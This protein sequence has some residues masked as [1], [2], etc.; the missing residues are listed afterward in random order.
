MSIPA[1]SASLLLGLLV[2]ATAL[3][4]MTPSAI[5]DQFFKRIVAGEPG[6]AFDTLMGHSRLDEVEPAE[7]SA[8]KGRLGE[9]ML[10]YGTPGS[11]EEIARKPYGDSIVRLVYITK[12]TDSPLVWNL[13][14]YR[15]SSDWQLLDFDFS[16]NLERLE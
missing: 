3:A 15:A 14:F 1:R 10:L 4:Q 11:Y 16:Q 13:Y 7:I 8:A 9:G 6:V 12:H 5:A 2:S